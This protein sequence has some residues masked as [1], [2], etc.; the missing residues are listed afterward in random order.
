MAVLLLSTLGCVPEW[1]E[2]EAFAAKLRCGMSLDDLRQ[3]GVD[4]RVAQF[5]APEV[6]TEGG[7]ALYLIEGGTYMSFWFEEGRLVAYGEGSLDS[8]ES[9][10]LTKHDLCGAHMRPAAP[11]V[12]K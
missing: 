2:R 3:L 12:H 8:N 7:P 1:N 9:E 6:R 5:D 4:H 10:N 11:P